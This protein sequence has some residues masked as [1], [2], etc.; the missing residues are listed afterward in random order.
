MGGKLL[1]FFVVAQWWIEVHDFY[2][3]GCS[4]IH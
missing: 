2:L 3:F 1:I 4:I